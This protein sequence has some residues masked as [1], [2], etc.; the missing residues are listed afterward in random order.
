M[1][2]N[3]IRVA[4]LI[5]AGIGLLVLEGCGYRIAD[6]T[7]TSTKNLNVPINTLE[8]GPRLSGEDC[9]RRILFFI[10]LGHLMPDVKAATDEALEKNGSN[11]LLDTVWEYQKVNL[12][13]Y[14]SE[15]IKVIGTTVKAN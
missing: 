2:A 13:I 14:T 3:T 8:M 6:F 15:C 11:F 1:R 12:L 5:L 10:P 4:S 7:A 9:A